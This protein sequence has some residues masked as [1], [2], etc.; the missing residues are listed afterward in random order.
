VGSISNSA[1]V[2]VGAKGDGTDWFPGLI[3]YIRI[4]IG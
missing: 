3:D 2:Y 1:P 4:D